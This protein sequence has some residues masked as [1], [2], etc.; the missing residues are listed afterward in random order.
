[1][2]LT[3][4]GDPPRS[5]D[6]LSEI[7]VD[8]IEP[9]TVS[10]SPENPAPAGH[11]PWS[12]RLAVAWADLVVVAGLTTAMIGAVILAGYPLSIRALPWAVVVALFGWGAA[13]GIILRVRR[14]TPGMVLAGLVFADEVAGG[15]LVLTIAAAGFSALLLGLPVLPGGRAASLLSVASGSALGGR[16]ETPMS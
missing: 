8:D 16:P 2:S 15:R 7:D 3:G 13:C 11:V 5:W 4:S 6:Q 12:A 9:D 10:S 1:M 14:G